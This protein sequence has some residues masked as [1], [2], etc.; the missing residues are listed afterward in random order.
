VVAL[1]LPLSDRV[2][3]RL[4]ELATLSSEATRGSIAGQMKAMAMIVAIEGLIPSGNTN[5]R[6]SASSGTQPT[7][8]PVK[9]DIYKS[10]WSREPAAEELGH[11]MAVPE[12]Q[13]AASLW[14]R[15]LLRSQS[16]LRIL[17]RPLPLRPQPSPAS[18]TLSSRKAS[19]G[20]PSRQAA[21]S[22]LFQT[23]GSPSP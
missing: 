2:L 3:D 23:P 12:A 9:A 5:G 8:S 1:L 4:W 15:S 7:P 13:P 22:M 21:A 6:R 10:A 20:F 11:P 14:S 19:T 18:P 17:P 16:L